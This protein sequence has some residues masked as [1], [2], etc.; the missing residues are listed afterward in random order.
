M[1]GICLGFL[2]AIYMLFRIGFIL[3]F[4]DILDVTGIVEWITILLAGIRFDLSALIY[5]NA[6]FLF[7]AL[8][9]IAYRNRII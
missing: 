8:L 7:F 4:N 3:L 1:A 9:P 6:P 2:L 5:V